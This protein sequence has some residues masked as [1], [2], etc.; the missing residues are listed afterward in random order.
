MAAAGDLIERERELGMLRRLA[1]EGRVTIL[2]PHE[3][4]GARGNGRLQAITVENTE[5]GA[6][7]EIWHDLFQESLLLGRR[8][9]IMRAQ[10]VIDIALW[11]LLGKQLDAPL[12]RLLGAA[13]WGHRLC[14]GNVAGPRRIRHR[15]EIVASGR[16]ANEH[17]RLSIRRNVGP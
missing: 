5:T 6:I 4:R 8:G 13:R 12:A 7:D 11:D 2:T 10:S 1:D 9:A 16:I 17:D 14:S 15:E 3:V